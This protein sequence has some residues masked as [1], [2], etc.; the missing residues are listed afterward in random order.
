MPSACAGDG[1]YLATRA[2][3][4]LLVSSIRAHSSPGQSPSMRLGVSA[5]DSRPRASARRLA[6][7]MVTTTDRRPWRA[8]SKA[9]TA[10]VVVLPTPPDPQHTMT[11][12][13][14]VSGPNVTAVPISLWRR[15]FRGFD[16]IGEGGGQALDLG[17]AELGAE[18][19]RQVKLR[20]V[21]ARGQAGHLLFLELLTG[22]AEHSRFAEGFVV[23]GRNTVHR[24]L[25]HVETV[26]WRV[27]AV[28]DD[29]RE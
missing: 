7:S 8:P 18:H 19:E 5:S 1:A 21:H 4:V 27:E 13:V 23:L 12:R 24:R 2:S 26:E 15:Q 16:G 25:V 6:G 3:K 17:R 22:G 29:G 28:D 9:R 20:E 10:A 14:R 11:R